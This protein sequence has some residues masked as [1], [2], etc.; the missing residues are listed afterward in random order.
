MSAA[1]TGLVRQNGWLKENYGQHNMAPC[2]WQDPLLHSDLPLARPLHFDL[3]LGWLGRC[4]RST[5]VHSM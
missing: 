2:P 1:P 3:P 4:Q 5:L